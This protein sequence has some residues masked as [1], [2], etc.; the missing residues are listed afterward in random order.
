MA[1]ACRHT[2]HHKDGLEIHVWNCDVN[3]AHGRY[4][5]ANGFANVSWSIARSKPLQVAHESGRVVV[6]TSDKD[7]EWR[8][9]G[10]PSDRG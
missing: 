2:L 1:K 4:E 6:W 8:I 9:L 5:H 3:F 10:K 7:V